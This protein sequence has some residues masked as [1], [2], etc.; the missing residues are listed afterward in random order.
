MFG[1]KGEP[2]YISKYF[3]EYL[4]GKNGEKMQ[5]FRKKFEEAYLIFRNKGKDLIS[6]LRIILS[7]GFQEISKKSIMH[8]DLTLSFSKTEKE[9]IEIINNAINYVMSR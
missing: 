7:S 4:G 9:A 6:L 3:I 2:F 1:D 5:L 8:L